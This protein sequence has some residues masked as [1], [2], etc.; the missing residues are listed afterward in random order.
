[1][2]HPEID[3]RWGQDSRI[4]D[5]ETF[6]NTIDTDLYLKPEVNEDVQGH[7]KVIKSLIELSYYQYEFI[8][9]AVHKAFVS[10]EMAMKFRHKEVENTDWASNQTMRPLIY[11]FF[12]RGYFETTSKEY[13]E[14]MIWMR[15]HFAHPKMHSFG[16][17]FTWHNI[18]SPLHF[19]NDLYENRELR[20]ERHQVNKKIDVVIEHL[21]RYGAV[22]NIE[23]HAPKTIYFL[24]M[25]FINNKITPVTITLAYRTIFIIPD[26]KPG[27]P[28]RVDPSNE[29]TCTEVLT[30]GIN[31]MGKTTNGEQ[32][33]IAP[34]SDNVTQEEFIR[35]RD[36][37]SLFA[38]ATAHHLAIHSP[39]N[40]RGHLLIRTF[41]LG[42]DTL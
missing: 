14:R 22:L 17:R 9:L 32:F 26:Y 30:A 35:W 6:Y 8:D 38:T 29:L 42:N 19:I 23:N 2:P 41:Y 25:D 15:N 3:P 1:M 21:T 31:L 36:A 33:T 5:Y 39:I 20:K 40:S 37:Y 16:G 12:S 10:F 34:I 11:W 18:F 13:I 7:W 27:D 28:C 24:A 4:L